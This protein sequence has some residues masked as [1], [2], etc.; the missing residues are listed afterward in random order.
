MRGKS[1]S[2]RENKQAWSQ[3]CTWGIRNSNVTV[4]GAEW[5]ELRGG[6]IL[7]GLNRPL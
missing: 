3:E 7:C 1:I 4:A 5:E 2:A 6:K